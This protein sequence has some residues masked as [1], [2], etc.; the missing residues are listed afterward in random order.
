MI[1]VD[2]LSKDAEKRAE[3]DVQKLTDEFVSAVD[4]VLKEKE[5]DLL[6]I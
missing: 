4:A 2:N 6:E 3:D 5:E 1:K